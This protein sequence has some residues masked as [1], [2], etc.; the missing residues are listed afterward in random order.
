MEDTLTRAYSE[1]KP[2]VLTGDFNIDILKEDNSR[3][4]TLR[5]EWESLYE[6]FEL[7]QIIKEPTRVTDRSKSLI[8]HIYCWVDLPVLKH[9]VVQYGI[10]DPFPIVHLM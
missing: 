2:L 10:S 9:A 3:P 6:N 1:N 8:D 7:V 5:T 4:N